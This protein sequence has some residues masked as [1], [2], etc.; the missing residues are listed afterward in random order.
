MT[1]FLERP[2]LGGACRDR[3]PSVNAFTFVDT[4]TWSPSVRREGTD[5]SQQR[6]LPNSQET[7]CLE[8]PLGGARALQ[9]G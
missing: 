6:A 8:L 4:L 5:I 3:L 9:L 2:A 1:S 7:R